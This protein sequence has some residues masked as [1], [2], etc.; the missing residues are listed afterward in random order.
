VV[1]VDDFGG[2]FVFRRGEFVGGGGDFAAEEEESCKGEE[3]G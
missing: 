1:A 2:L 3:G